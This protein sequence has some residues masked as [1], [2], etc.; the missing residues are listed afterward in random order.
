MRLT[1]RPFGQTWADGDVANV[2]VRRDAMS[3]ARVWRVWVLLVDGECGEW[4]E[5]NSRL[6]AFLVI[7]VCC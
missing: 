2:V 5:G 6:N 4:V 7:L 3:T 1:T